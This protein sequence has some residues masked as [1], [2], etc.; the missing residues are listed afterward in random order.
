[1]MMKHYFYGGE[2]IKELKKYK[3]NSSIIEEL[4]IYYHGDDKIY[5]ANGL[6]SLG[7]VTDNMYTFNDSEKDEF[8]NILHTPCPV[9]KPAASVTVSNSTKKRILAYLYPIS[10]NSQNPHGTV[11]YFIKESV[12]TGLIQNVLDNFKGN[13]YII[14]ANNQII[15][16]TINDEKVY[17]DQLNDEILNNEGVSNVRINEKEYSIVS[18][19]SEENGWTFITLMEADQFFEQVFQ[20]KTFIIIILRFLLFV[21]LTMAILL[22]KKQYQPIQNLFE[23]VKTKSKNNIKKS[24]YNELEK[25][26]DTI[27]DIFDSQ[28][29][30]NETLYLQKPLASEQL[31]VKMLKGELKDNEKTT[32]MLQKFNIKMY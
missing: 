14:D 11:M 12:L 30:I 10:P 24:G 4:F 31:L 6:Y 8:I 7:T 28:E 20:M 1:Y 2:G 27:S 3:A 16:S 9:I 19:K 13:T 5:S 29:K 23:Q 18:T 25:I 26:E 32:S 15:A 17:Y 22:R 21:G